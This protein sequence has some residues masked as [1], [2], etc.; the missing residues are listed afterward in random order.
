MRHREQEDLRRNPEGF[1]PNYLDN[2]ST[3]AIHTYMQSDTPT[4]TLKLAH[5][6]LHLP[7]HIIHTDTYYSI[8]HMHTIK[9]YTNHTRFF[10][11]L[12]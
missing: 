11:I 3:A 12:T 7:I 6:H 2:V 1:K 5:L 8:I 10:F 9:N 4:K